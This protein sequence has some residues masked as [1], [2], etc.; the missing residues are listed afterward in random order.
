MLLTPLFAACSKGPSAGDVEA[1][2]EAEYDQ[3][4]SMMDSAIGSAGS[5]EVA[6][7]MSGMMA[8]MVPK[9]E[10]V[11]NVNCDEADGD[12]AYLCTADITQ[13]LQGETRTDKANF[14][15]HKVNDEWVLRQ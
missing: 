1:L 14:M 10:E 9:L 5:S 8:G 15:V 13:T 3:A 7:A 12:N 11:K 2:I 4:N 6:R